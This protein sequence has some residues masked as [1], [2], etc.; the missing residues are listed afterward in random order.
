MQIKILKELAKQIGE[1]LTRLPGLHLYRTYDFHNRV[2]IYVTPSAQPDSSGYSVTIILWAEPGMNAVPAR[3]SIYRQRY[4]NVI[5]PSKDFD[6]FDEK[7]I[8]SI[9]EWVAQQIG[10]I[11]LL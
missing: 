9:V 8:E 4:D 10:H 1:A 2:A 3:I 7:L 11:P 6:I 5:D